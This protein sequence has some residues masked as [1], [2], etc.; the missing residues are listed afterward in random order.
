VTA[1]PY[2]SC[3]A[4]LSVVAV[5]FAVRASGQSGDLPDRDTFLRETREAL[6]RSQRLWHLYSYK[7]RR[8]DVHMNP[9]GRMGTGDT[10]LFEVRPSPN[11]QLTYRRELERNGVPVPAAELERQ[12]AEYRE[13]VARI[14]R[15]HREDEAERA[16]RDEAQ[17]RARAQRMLDDVIGTLQFDLVR[18]EMRD[19]QPAIV[20]S[21]AARPNARPT[22]R[23]GR[24]AQV[25]KGLVWIDERSREV[26]HMQAT[27]VDD[28]SF[29]GFLAKMYAGTEAVVDRK[30]VEPGVWMPTRLSLSGGVRALFRRARIDY[31][32]EWFDY[33]RTN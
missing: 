25:F 4:R 24:I 20:V 30:E 31:V 32:L 14:E 15:R 13:R 5:L 2:R 8:T 18:R 9:F 23:E 28:V 10:H 12:D 27:A 3:A 1:S 7:E 19:G 11:P 22:T 17:A 6:A 33:R 21:F 26:R 29:G 16:R